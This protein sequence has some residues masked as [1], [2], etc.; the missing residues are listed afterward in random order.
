VG[1]EDGRELGSV[2]DSPVGRPGKIKREPSIPL[3]SIPKSIPFLSIRG[4]DGGALG[5]NDGV[6]TFSRACK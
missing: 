6:E 2:L 3:S 5:S 4:R 1:E